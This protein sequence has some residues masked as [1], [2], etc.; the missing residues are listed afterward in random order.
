V[1][2]LSFALL[3]ALPAGLTGCATSG[4]AQLDGSPAC[5]PA[6]ATAIDPPADGGAAS[7]DVEKI[8]ARSCALG[9]CHA[10]SPGAA[11]LTLP[12]SGAWVAN[13]VNRRSRED[14][15]LMLVTPGDPSRSWM[16]HKL[17]GDFCSLGA[18]CDPQLGCGL[19]MPLGKPLPAEDIITILL[20]VRAGA[21]P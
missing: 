6:N 1:R 12:P 14:P 21:P 4:A 3:V 2:R 13:V 5:E 19:R 18:T 16:V 9:G 17:R 11:D 10:G 15:A 7:G 20:W 8:L